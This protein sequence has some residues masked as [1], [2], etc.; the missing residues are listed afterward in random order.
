M[1]LLSEQLEAARRGLLDLSTR[2]RLLSLPKPGRSRGVVL[3]DD[4]DAGFVLAALADGR[5]F[6]FEAAADSPE[7]APRRTRRPVRVDGVAQADA[8]QSRA[9]ARRDSRLR[10]K[11]PREDLARR[12][13]D[14]MQDARTAR[15]ETGI[16]TLSLALGALAWR[17]PA[18][19]ETERLAPLALLPVVLER[20]GVSQVFRL[21]AT[22]G[23]VEENLSLRQK[24][25]AE[26]RV[27]LPPF[28]A[29]DFAPVA[30]ADVVQAAIGARENWR[31]EP[32]SLAVGLFSFQKFL[33]WRDLDPAVNPGLLTHGMIRALVGG[34]RLESPPVLD[35]DVDVDEAIP[36]ERLDHVMEMDGSQALAA[37]AVRRGGAA[38]DLAGGAARD[39]AGGAPRD[40]AGGAARDAAGGAARDAAGGAAR[41]A[42]GGAARD[43]AGGAARDAAGGAARD[44]AGGAARDAA[45]GPGD[46]P[47]HVVIQG[48]PGT[49]KSQTIATII[50]QA[51]LD[52]RSVLFVAE[53]LAALE[54]VERRLGQIGL[55][56]ACLELHAEK[57]SKR[58][59]LDE[60]RATL[61]APPVPMPDRAPV[62]R[63]LG[64]LRGRLNQHARAMGEAVGESGRPLH[65]VVGRLAARRAAGAAAPDFTL[66]AGDWD[67]ARIAA[68]RAAGAELAACAAAGGPGSIWR[69]VGSALD[70]LAQDR[71]MARLT[72]L[73]R[74]LTAGATALAPAAMVQAEPGPAGAAHLL[75]LS[76][77]IA[78]AP[79]HDAGAL[80]HPAWQAD[81]A[82]LAALVEATATLA[83][84]GRDA[85]LRPGALD[86]EGLDSARATLAEGGG[87]L[88]FLSSTHRAAKALAA[89]IVADRAPVLPALDAAIAG[90]AAARALAAGEA[91]GRAA[92]GTLWGDAAAMAALLAWRRQ[93]GAAAAA[94]L[95]A[96]MPVLDDTAVQA[97]LDAWEELAAATQL[98]LTQAFGQADPPLAE[99]AARLGDWAA[100]P[101]ALT[102]WLAWCRAVQAAGEDLAPLVQRLADGSLPPTQ[103]ADAL[104]D[105]L[106]EALLKAAMRARPELA[107]FDG[108]G[109]DRMLVD[110]AAADRDR[111]ALARR[112]VAAT[113]AAA[114]ARVREMPGYRL[115]LGEF[116]KKRGHLPV[117]ELLLRAGA[118]VQA[119]KPVFLMSPLSVAQMLAP[120]HGLKP[121]LTFDLLVMDEASQIEPVDALGAIARSRQV[122]VVG[123]D[124]Q[125]PPTRFF[126]RMTSEEEMPEEEEASD[127][128]AAREVESILGLAN[129]RGVP[130]VMLRWHYRSRHES[131]IATSNAQFYGGRL[132]VLPSPRG[133][134]A[135]LGLSLVKV[136]GAWQ[137]GAGVNQAEARAVA[138]AVLRHAKET[139]GE[140]LGVA[141]FSLRQRDAILDAVEALRR[142]DDSA[143]AFFTAHPHEPFFVKNLENVQGDERDAMFIS[144]GY[145]RG[146]D[147]KLAMRFGPLSA[148]GGERR[149]NVLI[150]R[151]KTRCV[152]FSGITADDIDLER[153]TGA[154][155]AALKAFLRFAESG[156]DRRATGGDATAP[157]AR[158]IAEEISAAGMEPVARVGSA[159]LFL[160]VAARRDGDYLLGVEADAAD[161]AALR[162]ARDRDNGR[163]AALGRMGW[164]LHRAWSLAWLQRP[165]AER[166]RLRA[167]LG[168]SPEEAQTAAPST[169]PGLAQPY[170][171]AAPEKPEGNI[172]DQ[173][174]ARLAALLAEIIRVEQPLHGDAVLERARLV[175]GQAAL[176]AT[177][178]AALQQALRLAKQLEGV[179]EEA[180]FWTAEGAPPVQP[181]DRRAS[182]PHL[183]RAA[184]LPPAEVQAAAAAL[185]AALPGSTEDELVAGVVRLLGLEA[186]A[187][188]A[189]AARIAALVGAGVLSPAAA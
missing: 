17:D 98:D 100:Q 162:G 161:W 171:E 104:Q 55:G 9:D 160:D 52:G 20:Q 66:P 22:G 101:E 85:R 68:A 29:E 119:A 32:D 57:Q 137:A 181:R 47:G 8:A 113:H 94:A 31:V 15:E 64:S 131:L 40:L 69:G 144:V 21:R 48:P 6:T 168:A 91:T 178:R 128:V 179:T 109:F 163:G 141:A 43:A 12:L 61:A 114:V 166:A 158:V 115:L 3:L 2:N 38:R 117:R 97:A 122:V 153:A 172:P 112:E 18:T 105:A 86:A 154:G 79:A 142:E 7:S 62:L 89:R 81:P 164:R 10:A 176:S 186:S 124:R 44:A 30:W 111:I 14:L 50:A 152:V 24:L 185:L 145:A 143:E 28:P 73:I 148:E 147:G 4:E 132:M 34:E 25:L 188:P 19:P 123:D 155:V 80:A 27:E 1:S 35:P 92:F 184:L 5:A 13:R 159:G 118:A 183:R 165:D 180:G 136:D 88:S 175:F 156:E 129:A 51:V 103:A 170:V 37:E 75:A 63:R 39:L 87:F 33:M 169:D 67:A 157:L 167:A 95:A 134:S 11:L 65:A 174:F 83:A 130:N 60:L 151:A 23:E 146:A 107:A 71:L 45:G 53:K 139:P 16:A 150:T 77:S 116:E 74:A 187:A 173:P 108:A 127:T 78:Q 189:I 41:D 76:A 90:Q 138:E 26:F 36:V 177:D 58:A 110:F 121:G 46:Q 133:R 72:V 106:D 135:A 96:G 125:M 82:P 182:A 120:P 49:G 140:T 56:P 70:P 42:A 99:I 84:A 93:H 59:V 126:Q 149:L 54:V 102:P